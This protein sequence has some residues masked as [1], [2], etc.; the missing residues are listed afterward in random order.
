MSRPWRSFRT[1]S[2]LGWQVESN[3]TDPFLFFVYSISRPIALSLILVAMYTF[4]GRVGPGHP[5]FSAMYVG[6]AF[7]LFV[8]SILVG[9]SFAVLDDRETYGMLKFAFLAPVDPAWYFVGRGMARLGIAAISVVLVLGMGAW[10]LHVRPAPAGPAFAIFLPALAL[11]LAS[12]M[13]MGVLLAGV[14]LLVTGHG[15]TLGEAVAGAMFVISGAV[16]PIQALPPF[17][18]PLGYATPLPYWIEAMRRGVLGTGP[19]ADFTGCGDVR[20]L[21]ELALMTAATV[22]VAALG[23]TWCERRARDLGLLD[24]RANY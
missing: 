12:L 23:F 4:V 7:Y 17:L 5:E 15:G 18:R 16:F 20:L 3:W 21:V 22:L 6:N 8:A 10:L 19:S 13:A 2:W 14:S 1:G 24:W 9:I 11:G